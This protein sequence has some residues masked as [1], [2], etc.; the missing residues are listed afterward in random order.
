MFCLVLFTFVY[1]SA[2]YDNSFYYKHWC[3]EGLKY[4]SDKDCIKKF[5]SSFD[6]SWQCP[7]VAT[8]RT[9][10]GYAKD[11]GRFS[12]VVVNTTFLGQLVA[13]NTN[14]CV[15][16]IKRGPRE[17]L[18]KYFCAAGDDKNAHETWFVKAS[19]LLCNAFQEFFQNLCCYERCAT[20]T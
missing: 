7:M 19:V 18:Y 13:E 6:R 20:F 4:L 10:D 12:D 3:G 15:I 17:P 11:T 9:T 14:A 2:G 5:P 1:L 8:H 16:L